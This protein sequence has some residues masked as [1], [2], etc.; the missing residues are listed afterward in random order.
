MK[1]ELSDMEKALLVFT[2]RIDNLLRGMGARR[3]SD[4]AYLL[5]TPAG[6]LTLELDG[7]F[8]VGYFASP[9]GGC[10]VTGRY[11]DRNTGKW[12]HRC[13]YTVRDLCD[14]RKV[15]DFAILL[16]G[17]QTFKMPRGKRFVIEQ[18]LRFQR[19]HVKRMAEVFAAIPD[20]DAPK[21]E[22]TEPPLGKLIMAGVDPAKPVKPKNAKPKTKAKPKNAKPKRRGRVAKR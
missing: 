1:T 12:L 6:P 15:E 20:P 2:A 22:G 7:N 19:R 14:P 8:I 16:D 17:I 9:F 13:P 4:G 5:N 3:L 11:S 21:C 10:L 18:E